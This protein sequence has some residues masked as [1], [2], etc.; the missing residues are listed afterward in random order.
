MTVYFGSYF[1]D[2]IPPKKLAKA[3]PMRKMVKSHVEASWEKPISVATVGNVTD[4][5]DLSI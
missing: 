2:N 3:Y 4:R 5:L 1:I